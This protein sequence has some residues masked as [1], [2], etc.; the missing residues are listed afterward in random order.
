[1]ATKSS[2]TKIATLVLWREVL[3]R[4]DEE[5]EGSFCLASSM[6]VMVTRKENERQKNRV[7]EMERPISS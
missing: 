5:E 4:D 6:L 3:Q 2:K 7:G 1:M